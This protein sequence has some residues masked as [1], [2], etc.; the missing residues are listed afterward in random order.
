MGERHIHN[1]LVASRRNLRR[2]TPR[3][4]LRAHQTGSFLVDIRPYYQRSAD[5]DIPGA[6]V[7][8]RNHLEWRLD[9]CS[10]SHIPE[11][12]AHDQHWIIICDQGYSSSLAAASLQAAGLAMATDVEGGFQQ[13]R[14]EGCPIVRGNPP[15]TARLATEDTRAIAPPER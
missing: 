3:Q 12:T 4:A 5:G 9:P 14:D 11:A 6:I 10:P 8:E 13:W 1:L 2:L 7:I 15:A